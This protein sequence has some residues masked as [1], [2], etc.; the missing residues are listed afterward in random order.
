MI[1]KYDAALQYIRHG[2]VLC[3]TRST[4]QK[5]AYG[6]GWQH[7]GRS[8]GHWDTHPDDGMGIVHGLSGT[9]SIDL[10]DLEK[11]HIAFE[12]VCVDLSAL[13][14]SSVQID[15]GR[16]NRAKMMFKLP[17]NVPAK[18]HALNWREDDGTLDC[19]LELR[20]GSVHDVLPPSIHPDTGKPYKWIGDWRSLPMLPDELAKIWIEWDLAKSAMMEADPN[21]VETRTPPPNA[22][23]PPRPAGMD[24]DNVIG[25]FNDAHDIGDLLSQH[26][27]KRA[28]NRWLAPNSSTGI[29]GVVRLPDSVPLHI[30]S[31]HGSD[32]LCDGYAHDAFSVYMLLECHGDI[33]KAVSTAAGMMGIKPKIDPYIEEALKNMSN[34][35]SISD[36]QDKEV[37]Q[38]VI[39]APNPGVMPVD[40]LCDV[41]EWLTGA[42]NSPKVDAVMQTVVSYAC[43]MTGRR[44][45]L[46]DGQP[47]SAFFGIYD[48]STAGLTEVKKI[49]DLC[50]ETSERITIRATDIQ[51]AASIYNS[52]ELH[53]RM[54][55]VT[56]EFNSLMHLSTKQP[57]GAARSAL[58]LIASL[59]DGGTLRLDSDTGRGASSRRKLDTMDI[60]S[61]ALTIL[62]LI[63]GTNI[64]YMVTREEYARGTPQRVLAIPAGNYMRNIKRSRKDD[65]EKL[66]KQV[67]ITLNRMS[68]NIS[69][70]RA[71]RD[72]PWQ[73]IN[74]TV[75]RWDKEVTHIFKES[76][77]K[78]MAIMNN[79]SREEFRGMAHGYHKS[80]MRIAGALAAWNNP[81]DPVIGVKEAY[82]AC[83]W[84][85]RCL[86]LIMPLV[87]IAGDDSSAVEEAILEV[88]NKNRG[89]LSINEVTRKTRA[90]SKLTKD[91]RYDVF[92]SL[93]EQGKIIII[94]DG[95]TFT[96]E[97]TSHAKYV[98]SK[99]LA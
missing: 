74:R 91:D 88:L 48:S 63:G 8:G 21:H 96:G 44:Y 57:S 5:E 29:P 36:K 35:V 33:Q 79:S 17:P 80:A 58:S 67:L 37:K 26:G 41:Q 75:V 51:S 69:I 19:V 28:G 65:L 90:V 56:P 70:D 23:L 72:S 46:M 62:S 83:V 31:F 49:Y 25:Q 94:K 16:K 52:F 42:L 39:E 12:A 99:V 3:A 15:S 71:A 13:L 97:A 30:Y 76:H 82:W 18:R 7:N 50:A 47:T 73:P 55:W 54:Y 95:K 86:T 27:Y 61:P 38:E 53:P 93:R 20:A 11:A 1:S 2:L 84:A 81:E 10:D 78:L 45:E 77:S 59:Y 89:G 66:S 4:N 9:C 85:Q 60:M 32:V 14:A 92:A 34:V 98:L 87:E 22:K 6:K 43:A 40:L 64:G 24:N 68:D